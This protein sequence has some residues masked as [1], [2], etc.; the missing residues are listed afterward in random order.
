MIDYGKSM[1]LVHDL[2]A[3][4][5]SVMESSA[6]DRNST[7]EPIPSRPSALPACALF[8]ETERSPK[9]G[10]VK[11]TT[12]INGAAAS[13]PHRP[14]NEAAFQTFLGLTDA[15]STLHPA[16]REVDDG[17]TT[18]GAKDNTATVIR[19]LNEALATAVVGILRYK[20][21]YFM[22][23]GISARRVRA[24]FLKHVTDEQAYADQLAERIKQLDGKALLPFER[25][26]NR[27]HAERVEGDSLGEM[28]TADLLA[29]QSTINNYRS[30]I[31]SI[32]ADDPTTRQVLGR[33]LVQEEAHAEN[34]ASLLMDWASTRECR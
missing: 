12:A 11:R 24:T 34:L 6:H 26:L 25:L 22:T 7:V 1:L 18:R 28:I 20:R 13:P 16:K 5:L 31:A 30:M 21:H 33:I 23:G 10:I 4:H 32:G 14:R 15:P 19:L 3:T 2:E 17:A 29:E 8:T 27:N 9:E